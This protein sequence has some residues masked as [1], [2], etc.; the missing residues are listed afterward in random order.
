MRTQSLSHHQLSLIHS[1]THS[2][3]HSLKDSPTHSLTHPPTHSLTHPLTHPLH[4]G[5]TALRPAEGAVGAGAV[6]VLDEPH[7]RADPL[8]HLLRCLPGRDL[9]LRRHQWR[10]D[11]GKEGRKE[12]RKKGR[13]EG[14]WRREMRPNIAIALPFPSLPASHGV[15]SLL[16]SA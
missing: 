12:G 15:P 14:S 16:P 6:T 5:S 1:L 13:K 10:G 11:A 7:G 4:L 2:P 3:T 8:V 9:P